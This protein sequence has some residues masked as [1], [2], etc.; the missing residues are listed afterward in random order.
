MPITSIFTQ[1]SFRDILFNWRFSE[2][3]QFKCSLKCT[4]FSI[5][6]ERSSFNY[7]HTDSCLL[8][9]HS[10]LKSCQ[11]YWHYSNINNTWSLNRCMVV[12]FTHL[13]IVIFFSHIQTQSVCDSVEWINKFDLAGAFFS[14]FNFNHKTHSESRSTICLHFF[15][16]RLLFDLHLQYIYSI[17]IHMRRVCSML[18]IFYMSWKRQ[19]ESILIYYLN[20]SFRAM[21]FHPQLITQDFSSEF[22]YSIWSAYFSAYG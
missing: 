7:I 15:S 6:V 14:S 10:V 4:W 22:F 8:C 12:L 9:L 18:H 5:C 3:I 13:F 16:R 1:L 21:F 19:I 2:A 11:C 17:N 20:E